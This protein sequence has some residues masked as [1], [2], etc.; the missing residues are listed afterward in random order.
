MSITVLY[1]AG[2]AERL[3]TRRGQMTHLSGDTVASVRDR[4]IAER[5]EAK[6]YM[7][8]LMFAVN[9]EYAGENT[10]IDDGAILALI[11]PVSGGAI[12]C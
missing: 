4:I 3:G 10:P 6:P 12:L 9:E 8:T 2:L 11:P 5:P 1:F 7:Q